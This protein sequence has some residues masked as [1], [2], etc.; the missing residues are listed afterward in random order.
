MYVP[1]LLNCKPEFVYVIRFEYPE[2]VKS[3]ASRRGAVSVEAM[4][5]KVR[6]LSGKTFESG[7]G[8]LILFKTK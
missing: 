5:L 2:R 3:D 4:D 1:L 7:R 8:E 6:P